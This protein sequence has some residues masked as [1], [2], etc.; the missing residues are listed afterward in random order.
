MPNRRPAAERLLVAW[1]RKAM[2]PE[3]AREVLGFPPRYM[4]SEAELSKA[5]RIR[6]REAHPDL[7]GSEQAMV[8]I[9]VAKEVLE[10]KRVNDLT[11]VGVDTKQRRADMAAIEKAKDRAVTAM[12]E[13]VSTIGRHL[14]WSGRIDLRAYL[15]SDYVDA[16]DRLHDFVEDAI[17][18]TTGKRQL[19]MKNI[20]GASRDVLSLTTRVGA[21]LKS[22]SKRTQAEVT[23]TIEGIEVLCAEFGRFKPMF[24]A[25]YKKSG[26]LVT[27][28]HTMI[29]EDDDGE[30][31]PERLT[32]AVFDGHQMIL[33]F[34]N[35]YGR[36]P[37]DCDTT[38]PGRVVEDAV[39]EVLT[40]L[41]R[42]GSATSTLPPWNQWDVTVFT[43]AATLVDRRTNASRVATRFLDLAEA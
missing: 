16:V 23:P 11:E 20:I 1:L 25:L 3:E 40:I 42:R 36:Y 5:V 9:N 26:A 17:K 13:A 28:L 7:G 10:G 38:K 21:K 8:E 33:A 37:P 30:F 18:E 31:V 2:S 22:L 4:P 35:D 29:S 19:R 32:E 34:R 27:L 24:D 43:H 15:T 14:F 12:D 39:G 41:Q 6:A